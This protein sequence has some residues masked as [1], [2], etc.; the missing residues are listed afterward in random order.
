VQ[1]LGPLT[2]TPCRIVR[3][4]CVSRNYVTAS[5]ASLSRSEYGGCGAWSPV[6]V[7]TEGGGLAEV[8]LGASSAPSGSLVC[9]A[10]YE[11]AVMPLASPCIDVYGGCGAWSPLS[12]DTEGG[13][14]A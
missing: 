13:G 1:A 8:L 14:L 10:L 11:Y 4:C 7:D 12:V 5:L 3:P 9:R 6:S 2:P